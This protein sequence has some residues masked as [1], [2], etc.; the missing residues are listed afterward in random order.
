MQLKDKHEKDI[1]QQSKNLL[2]IDT[3]HDGS[4]PFTGIGQLKETP[5]PKADEKKAKEV[6][7]IGS[8]GLELDMDW[9]HDGNEGCYIDVEAQRAFDV[10]QKVFSPDDN[11]YV[12]LREY[13]A[14]KQSFNCKI[15]KKKSEEEKKA[16]E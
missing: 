11:E 12:E 1:S 9:N 7:P 15:L 2:W 4:L 8:S 3:L 13:D 14:T 10:Y 5:E 6:A 16:E